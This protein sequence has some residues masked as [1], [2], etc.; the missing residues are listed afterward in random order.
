[1]TAGAAV[2]SSDRTKDPLAP[3]KRAIRTGSGETRICFAKKPENRDEN[4][5]RD[6]LSDSNRS[7]PL[8]PGDLP[9]ALPNKDPSPDVP[10]RVVGFVFPGESTG[11]QTSPGH[12][13]NPSDR[14]NLARPGRETNPNRRGVR[15]R[16]APRN[17]AN[18]LPDAG[19]GRGTKRTQAIDTIPQPP[20]PKRTQTKPSKACPTSPDTKRAQ[21]PIQCRA[22]TRSEPNPNNRCMPS[23]SIRRDGRGHSTVRAA[24]TRRRATLAR[25]S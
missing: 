24:W 18:E 9:H 21:R 17:E 8:Q 16:V 22:R 4:S 7:N 12:E 20:D 13:T 14:R 10:P 3:R 6:P 23:P 1:M 5:P 11:G 19:S 25:K 15:R 2:R